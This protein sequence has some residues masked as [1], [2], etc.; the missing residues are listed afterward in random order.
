METRE[1]YRQNLLETGYRKLF[2]IPVGVLLISFSV[3][4]IVALINRMLEVFILLLI[5]LLLLISFLVFTFY[6]VKHLRRAVVTITEERLIILNE[7]NFKKIKLN[8]QQIRGFIIREVAR[9]FK[10]RF[11]DLDK[12][13]YL[14]LI[15]GDE[16]MNKKALISLNFLK[17]REDFIERLKK[18]I[19]E[20]TAKYRKGLLQDA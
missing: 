14:N 6:A 7:L 1:Y 5:I 18:R 16:E 9:P 19:P 12:E 10:L 15:T 17:N 11:V 3:L 2:L 8:W 4:L 20:L 13:I